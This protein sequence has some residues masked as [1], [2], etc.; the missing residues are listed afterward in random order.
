MIAWAFVVVVMSILSYLADVG[1]IS[2]LNLRIPVL[3][4]S[5]MSVVLLLCGLGM[6][7]RIKYMVSKGEK[8]NLHDKVK[9]LEQ[10]LEELKNAD[11][12]KTE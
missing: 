6:M 3:G 9:K 4:A 10:R 8:E 5:L 1:V 2:I 7:G 11:G 12:S